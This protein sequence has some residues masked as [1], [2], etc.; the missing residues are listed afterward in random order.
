MSKQ[1]GGL[2]AIGNRMRMPEATGYP[3]CG[4]SL[5]RGSEAEGDK[6]EDRRPSP[7]PPTSNFTTRQNF[8]LEII[9][10]PLYI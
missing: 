6:P 3:L 2:F 8:S 1:S 9:T 5:R 4:W 10:D 7:V